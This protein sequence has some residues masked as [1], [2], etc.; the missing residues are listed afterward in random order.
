MKM[1]DYILTADRI[2]TM[3]EAMPQADWVAIKD[4]KI[5]KVG[6]G[7]IPSGYEVKDFEKRI[8]LPGLIDSHVHG[9]NTAIL[10]AGVNL[11]EATSVSEALELIEQRCKSTDEDIVFAPFFIIPQ[12]KE[13]RFPTRKELDKVSNGKK[14]MVLNITLHSSSINSAS[15][16]VLGF[17]G[18]EQGLG[19]DE[20]GKF[21]GY[22]EDD[23]INFR[24]LGELTARLSKEKIAGYIDSFGQM[25]AENGITTAHCLEGQ[26][27]AG[28]IDLD[29]W[30]EKIK[31][32][33]LPFHCV[34]YPQIWDYEK[35]S[36]YNL[37]RH[38]GCL[39]LD[40]ADTDFTMALDEPYTNNP[41]VR[42]NLYWRDIDV[43]NLTKKAYTD[44]K[45]IAFHAMGERAIDQVLDAYRRVIAEQ[46]QKNLRL[47]IE[48]FSYPYEKHIAMAAKLG[49]V[50]GMQPEYTYLFDVPGGA[51]EQWVGEERAKRA[52][53]YKDVAD[54]GVMV[55]GGSDAPVNSLNPLTGIHGLVN[56]TREGRRMSVTEALKTYTYN[57][58]YAAFEENERG[59]IKEGFFA[60]FTVLD[61]DPYD[62]P[63]KIN[64]IKVTATISEGRIVFERTEGK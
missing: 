17:N 25:C 30:M 40:G 34:L 50:A 11:M 6:L 9:C 55:A 45:Q 37:P 61:E 7:E 3:D 20:D 21:N 62:V 42:G 44:G 26:F 43:Y 36:K 8:V 58:A 60:D 28:D 22:L 57:A 63:H 41:K 47:R 14:V 39:T 1:Y 54:K 48:H 53:L 27:I 18:D 32:D 31:A 19:R 12:I 51:L 10:L 35:A 2:Y 5:V 29:I 38:G 24:T 13:G 33:A 52:E 16:E 56:A 4:R 64:E 15:Y 23:D 59:T 46:G 49:V